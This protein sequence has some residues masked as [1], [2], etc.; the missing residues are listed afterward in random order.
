MKSVNIDRSLLRREADGES[1]ISG[2]RPKSGWLTSLRQQLK[3]SGQDL[4]SRLGL[5]RNAVYQAERNERNGTIT[6]QQLEKVAQGMGG[7]LVYAVI[8]E[9]SVE[10]IVERRAYE[11]AKAIVNQSRVH[12]VM[13]GQGVSDAVCQAQIDSLARTLMYQRP[14]DFWRDDAPAT[15]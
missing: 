10:G 4:A 5:S 9:P 6:L 13:E 3:M 11:K 12:M 7:R 1:W 2:P 14:K 15:T 8:P